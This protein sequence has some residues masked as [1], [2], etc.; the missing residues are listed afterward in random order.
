MARVRRQAAEWATLID[1]WRQSGLS[2]PAF[3]ERHGLSR[4]TMQNWVYKPE[5][6]RAVDEARREAQ[7]QATAP[8]PVEEPHTPATVAAFVPVRVV[9]T[10][11]G[12]EASDRSGVEV[13]IGTGR[14]IAVRAGFDAET[15]RRVVAV[16]EGRTC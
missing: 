2:L 5:L 3:C 11:A 10:A 12:G 16:L 6:K 7:G 1:Q 14:R 9:E 15:L 4:G 13:V 8:R